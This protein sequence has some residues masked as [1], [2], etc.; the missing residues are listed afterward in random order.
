MS[1][2]EFYNKK[3]GRKLLFVTIVYAIV[4]VLLYV[5]IYLNKTEQ[6]LKE[7]YALITKLDNKITQGIRFKRILENIT[8]PERK[9]S[10]ILA[11]QFLDN[12]K[13]R[14][15]EI[16]IE[17]SNIQKEQKQ[18]SYDI[19]LKAE[20]LWNRVVDIL[21][22]LEETEYPL[23]FIKSVALSSKGNTTGIDIK[24]HL[25]LFYQ[26]SEKRT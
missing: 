26:E 4:M 20:T 3:I 8:V 11:A 23:I 6:A 2:Q 19:T 10:E 18:L 17:I 1:I 13:S 9:D 21:S 14:F 25:K 5:F 16:N 24:V 22:F 7:D 15:P 12:L